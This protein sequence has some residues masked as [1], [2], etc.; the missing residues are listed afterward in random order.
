M[1]AMIKFNITQNNTNSVNIQHRDCYNVHLQRDVLIVV[2]NCNLIVVYWK[3]VIHV[4]C[5][6]AVAG[7]RVAEQGQGH[8]A[9]SGSQC[10]TGSHNT[11]T[12]M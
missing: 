12:C 2:N 1:E 8:T 11:H 6:L 10:Q 4:L 7:L 5:R 3:L 9:S